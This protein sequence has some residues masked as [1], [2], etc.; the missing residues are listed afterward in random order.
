MRVGKK[1]YIGSFAF[2]LDQ[3]CDNG[4]VDL[5]MTFLRAYDGIMMTLHTCIDKHV[6]RS[7][8][9]LVKRE[10]GEHPVG[11]ASDP[12]ITNEVNTFCRR[13][14]ADFKTLQAEAADKVRT[15]PVSDIRITLREVKK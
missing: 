8:S 13:F 11:V 1:K 6:Q 10:G 7:S 5:I 3:K 9:K 14:T 15:L 12:V 2:S 4:L